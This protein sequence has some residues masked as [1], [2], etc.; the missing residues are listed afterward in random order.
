MKGQPVTTLRNIGPASALL[1]SLS[2]TALAADSPAAAPEK[3]AIPKSDR[4]FSMTRVEEKDIVGYLHIAIQPSGDEAAPVRIACEFKQ[5]FQGSTPLWWEDVCLSLNDEWLSPVRGT[6]IKH[7]DPDDTETVKVVITRPD[8]K[9]T[10]GKMVRTTQDDEKS[11]WDVKARTVDD[12]T[13]L[14]LALRRPFEK[15][16]TLDLADFASDC[17]GTTDCKLSYL[18][19]EE[20]EV[21]GQK[22]EL[23]KFAFIETG[24]ASWDPYWIWLTDKHELACVRIEEV[25]LIPAT[26]AEARKPVADL[27][28]RQAGPLNAEMMSEGIAGCATIRAAMRVRFAQYNVYP[29][30]DGVTGDQLWDSLHVAPADLNGKYFKAAGYV[31][32]STPKDYTIK[33]TLGAQTYVIDE[34]GVESGT[35]RTSR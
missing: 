29:T 24:D 14:D 28:A 33:A 34:K 11:E 31:V 30:L 32:N 1:L 4:W 22:R 35:Y 26:E 12:F 9:S 10:A 19:Q 27:E 15:D 23:H 17:Q 21:R 5:L 8:P 6:F 3:P 18:G 20:L 16:K 25:M 7:K 2:I 13:P